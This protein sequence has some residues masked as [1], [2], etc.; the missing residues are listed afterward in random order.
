MKQATGRDLALRGPIS[1]K[2]SLWP[3]LQVRDV[4]LA[5][6]PGFSR[7]E[8]ATLGELDL[9]LA[10]WPLLSH[11]LE[12]KRLVL[13]HPDIRLETDAQGRANWQVAPQA[14]A[15]ANAPAPQS[16]GSPGSAMQISVEQLRV[17]DGK[18]TWRDGATGKTTT[19][20]L[21]RLQA[22]T[23]AM[24]APLHVS[25]DATYNNTAIN[26]AAQFGPLQRLMQPTGADTPWPVQLTV[27]AAGAKVSAD[28]S[29]RQPLQGRGYDLALTGT[30]PDLNALTPLAPG[31]KL[32]P[33]HDVR[34]STRLTDSGGALPQVSALTLHVG[35]SDL[36]S[37]TGGPGCAGAGP[38]RPRA[39]PAD[40]DQAA[41]QT[42]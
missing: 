21:H 4:I 33:L 15:S 3:T 28:G 22:T 35:A 30:I 16:S 37:T 2:P 24:T 17:E 29:L 40:A 31:V 10:L 23:T 12:I 38:D 32:P 13:I 42:G 20:G 27:Q 11:R 9:Q 6:P 8:M 18:L 26:L 7:P 41:G 39:G 25:A 36:G 34:F 14:T 19:L 1:F 5:N